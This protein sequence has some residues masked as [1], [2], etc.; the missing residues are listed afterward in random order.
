MPIARLKPNF[1]GDWTP[2]VSIASQA[3][4]LIEGKPHRNFEIAFIDD[5]GEPLVTLKGYWEKARG[6]VFDIPETSFIKKNLTKGQE[7]TLLLTGWRRNPS[8]EKISYIYALHGKLRIDFLAGAVIH[9][10]RE[11]IGDK[12]DTWFEVKVDEQP[13]TKINSKLFEIHEKVHNRFR[14]KVN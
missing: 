4:G 12:P 2:L 3:I 1:R 10:I 5:Q 6:I 7:T 13:V 11:I 8:K 14:I 9:A